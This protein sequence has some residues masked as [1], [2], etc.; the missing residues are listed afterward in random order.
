M[1]DIVKKFINLEGLSDIHIR[2]NK[3]VSLRI[4]GEIKRKI[5]IGDELQYYNNYQITANLAYTF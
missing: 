5:V 4:N 3:P 1:D 2:S